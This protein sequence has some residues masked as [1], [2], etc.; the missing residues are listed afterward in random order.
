MT[1]NWQ[2]E[3]AIL[4]ASGLVDTPW[5]LTRYADVRLL[6][7]GAAE[8]YLKYGAAMRRDPSPAFDTHFYLTTYPDVALTGQNPLLHYLL[9]GREEGRYGCEKDRF[10]P[11][12]RIG[13]ASRR[14][15]VQGFETRPVE[16]LKTLI[17]E[18][19]NNAARAMA[20]TEIALWHLH[21]NTAE[22]YAESLACLE[23]AQ[24]LASD[25]T[26]RSRLILLR[27]LCHYHLQ[28]TDQARTLFDTAA[29]QGLET[30]DICL[31]RANFEARP[32]DRLRFINRALSHSDIPH[33]S[34]QPETGSKI[35]TAYDRLTMAR[36]SVSPTAED[37]TKISVLIA[38]YNAAET[39][40][41]ALTSLQAQSW[42]NLEIIVI[43][44]ASTDNTVEIVEQFARH[45][46][47]IRLLPLRENG[48][49]YIARN[50]GLDL[51]TGEYITLHDADDWSHPLKLEIQARYLNAEP[52]LMG[53]TSQ[54]ARAR[55]DLEFTRCTDDGRLI[56][57]NTSSLMF[58]RL[59]IQEACGYWDR[60]RFSAD[61]EFI[62]RIRKIF[63]HQAVQHLTTGPLS[64]QRD[65]ETSIIAHPFFGINGS[66][67]GIRHEYF[68]AQHFHH[69][70]AVSLRYDNDPATRPFPV[71]AGLWRKNAPARHFDII[72]GA[73]F[74]KDN[75][76]TQRAISD[77]QKLKSAGLNVG[78]VQIYDYDLAPN[79]HQLILDDLR[80][81]IDGDRCQIL[82]YGEKAT[83]DQLSLYDTSVL[84]ET[85]TFLPDIAADRIVVLSDPLICPPTVRTRCDA[86]ILRYFAKEAIW[87]TEPAN[88]D[89][90]QTLY[91][92]RK[93]RLTSL[94]DAPSQDSVFFRKLSS[95]LLPAIDDTVFT[96]LRA[97]QS[98]LQNINHPLSAPLISVI[99]PTHNRAEIIAEA[100]QSLRDQ[101][102]THW[103]LL[104]C[105][106]AST[107]NT[108]A[109]VRRF[110]DE[111]IHYLLLEK[112]GAAAA[113]N[114]GLEKAR[115]Q[116]IAYLD[117]DNY[118]HPD[119]LKMVAH[120]FDTHPDTDAIYGDYLDY[121]VSEDGTVTIE[122][123]Q[124]PAFDYGRLRSKNYIDLN[125]FAHRR[126]LYD[127]F[128]GFNPALKRRQ[129][130]DLILKYTWLSDPLHI[131]HILALYQRNAR[132]VQ[133][134]QSQGHDTTCIDIIEQSLHSYDCSGL[135]VI[136]PASDAVTLI[137]AGKRPET[138]HKAMGLA[139]AL[140]PAHKVNTLHISPA[141]RP[142]ALPAEGQGPIILV[143]D[144]PD[145][146]PSAPDFLPVSILFRHEKTPLK[147]ALFTGNLLAGPTSPLSSC[148][149]YTPA[150]ICARFNLFQHRSSEPFCTIDWEGLTDHSMI[151]QGRNQLPQ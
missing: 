9:H 70:H 75:H 98:A 45:D 105:D 4:E 46:P 32:E 12:R 52:A 145:H 69:K 91:Q 2:A 150:A 56:F 100:I 76:P 94:F 63:G 93:A 44:D 148:H 120:Q 41:T 134:T 34:L 131:Q 7:M 21:K 35:R 109:V 86:H 99:M 73:D 53:C 25:D 38:A 58:R 51:A 139:Q 137:I 20:Y 144:M 5:Y 124:R 102:H 81:L 142:V 89:L 82:T 149:R 47:R 1:T 28:Q 122:S 49:A 10:D 40:P 3:I 74:R 66:P 6:G 118:W 11:F 83:C 37:Q 26:H 14:L 27:L 117:S 87:A 19:D 132:L 60:V 64:F 95:E 77:I 123:Y 84:L 113:R 125:S 71:P 110:A 39:L 141:A 103:E 85:Q 136:A 96:A 55:S 79:P 106:D 147:A 57:P 135:P 126:E 30:A 127:A 114:S 65:S 18:T 54:Q 68:E 17:A 80:M 146:S 48:G 59:P 97:S 62:R 90:I 115:G 133:I 116:I 43:D 72:L 129:D 121:R 138:T 61:N 24:P 88:E 23:Q 78:I 151:V 112:V 36:H 67:R 140:S 143:L 8:H 119:Y 107:D 101:S 16:D 104:V 42:Q 15:R 111:R 13:E 22:D 50:A 33:I 108:D 31:A 128:G 130:Y 92:R 29:T